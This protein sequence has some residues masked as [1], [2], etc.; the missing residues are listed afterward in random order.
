VRRSHR[1][2]AR[3][4]GE[5]DFAALARRLAVLLT[6]ARDGRALTEGSGD[7]VLAPAVGARL[8]AGLLPLLVG[9]EAWRGVRALRDRKGRVGSEQL[10]VVDDGRLA[11]GVFSAP[12]DGEGVPTRAVALIER[13]LY[14][15]PLLTWREA[16][17]G[18]SV[19]C[20]CSL[21]P[22]WRKPPETAPSHLFIA[23]H[24][25]T[26]PADLVASVVDGFY[27]LDAPGPGH[28]DLAGDRFTLPV[29][30]FRLREGRAKEPIAGARLCG[31][32]KA[33]LS[34]IRA[35]GRDLDFLPLG[36]LVGAPT[37][38]VTGLTLDGRPQPG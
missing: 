24:A 18:E 25:E 4:A 29:S 33:L 15:Q 35:T 37:L 20:G 12:V 9:A 22:S 32:V 7:M 5:I 19:A 6:I 36:H 14:R 2:A 3:S 38:L 1:L 27:W 13:G 34:G 31:S 8:L 16:E 11:G 28:F 23:P 30:G 26:A 17:P 21:R 10:T